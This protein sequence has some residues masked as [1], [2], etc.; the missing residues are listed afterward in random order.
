MKCT[1]FIP[2]KSQTV[3]FA[4]L[5]YLAIFSTENSLAYIENC[6]ERIREH[7]KATNMSLIIMLANEGG[8]NDAEI[9]NLR[10]CG[11]SLAYRYCF[12]YVFVILSD[13]LFAMPTIMAYAVCNV[14]TPN[15]F[16]A[17]ALSVRL[18]LISLYKPV[19]S[20]GLLA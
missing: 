4:I 10:S 3:F 15:M 2:Q 20:F 12:F 8:M 16:L 11:Q 18:I 6:L 9:S 1:L 5:G 17:I 14:N 13:F 19:I 7:E